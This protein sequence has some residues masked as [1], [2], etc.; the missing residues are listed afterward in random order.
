MTA[1]LSL[2][3]LAVS[4]NDPAADVKPGWIPLVIVLAIGAVIAFLYFSMKKQL[5]R[6]DF[7]EE[8][9]KRDREPGEGERPAK[10]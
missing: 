5:G 7:D 10:P 1:H 8:A 9:T 2:L 3:P 6:I 4:S